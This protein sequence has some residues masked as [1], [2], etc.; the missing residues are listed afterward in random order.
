MRWL[1][2]RLS[3]AS[4]SDLDTVVHSQVKCLIELC[5]MCNL[6]IFNGPIGSDKWIGHYTC[7]TY[8]GASWLCVVFT[9]IDAIYFWFWCCWMHALLRTLSYSCVICIDS[10]CQ[11]KPEQ[12]ISKLI[13]DSDKIDIYR[14]NLA[15]NSSSSTFQKLLNMIEYYDED[16]VINENVKCSKM[17]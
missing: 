11:R 2:K 15:N 6:R 5:H 12:K 8:S 17:F 3:N 9:W 13:W 7:Y 14:Q 1:H 4:Q 16:T 10:H